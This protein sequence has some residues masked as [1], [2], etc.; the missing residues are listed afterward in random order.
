MANKL[1]AGLS[2]LAYPAMALLGLT[3]ISIVLLPYTLAPTATNS[4]LVKTDTFSVSLAELHYRVF[5][6][7]VVPTDCDAVITI[8]ISISM[9]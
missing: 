5:F 1:R 2:R 7:G 4:R 3:L 9:A 6:L 8:S